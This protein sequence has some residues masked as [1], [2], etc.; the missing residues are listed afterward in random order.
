M[1]TRH[2]RVIWLCLTKQHSQTQKFLLLLF[3]HHSTE[4]EGEWR[5]TDRHRMGERERE[6]EITAVRQETFLWHEAKYNYHRDVLYLS[7]IEKSN[8]CK[9]KKE[10][11]I[12]RSEKFMI[13]S[14]MSSAWSLVVSWGPEVP[15]PDW[16]SACDWGALLAVAHSTFWPVPSKLMSPHQKYTRLQ[17]TVK[18]CWTWKI[19][20]Y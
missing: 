3:S 1:W 20:A 19:L 9:E 17:R 10:A 15:W 13:S 18:M 16:L 5:E 7:K 6:R 8:V 2:S 11:E 4:T 14:E 12:S